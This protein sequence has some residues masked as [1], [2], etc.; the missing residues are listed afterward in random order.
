MGID[1]ANP[2]VLNALSDSAPAAQVARLGKPVLILAG[3]KDKMVDIAGVTDYVAR[4]QGLDK[5][6]TLLIDPDEGHQPRKPILRQAYIHLLL[7]GLHRH[8]GGPAPAAP[9]PELAK[10]LAQTIKVDTAF[11]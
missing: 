10:Y 1:L 4:L 7:R 6:V 2:A 5:P 3:G 8:L 11:N 9:G